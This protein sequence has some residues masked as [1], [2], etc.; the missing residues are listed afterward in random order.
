VFPS[1]FPSGRSH[2]QSFSMWSFYSSRTLNV[3]R[4]FT[5]PTVLR[6][7]TRIFTSPVTSTASTLIPNLDFSTVK[8]TRGYVDEHKYHSI[9]VSYGHHQYRSPSGNA[10]V[11]TSYQSNYIYLTKVSVTAFIFILALNRLIRT[12]RRF[13][14]YVQHVVNYPHAHRTLLNG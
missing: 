8:R 7:N 12:L 3:K 6:C 11:V 1:V 2:L 13:V 9:D 4:F 10:I 14:F 5:P